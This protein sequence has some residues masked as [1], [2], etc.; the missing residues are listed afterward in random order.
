MAKTVGRGREEHDRGDREHGHEERDERDDICERCGRCDDEER[1]ERHRHNEKIV[2]VEKESINWLRFSLKC[3]KSKKHR[4]FVLLREDKID[5]VEERKEGTIIVYSEGNRVRKFLV[6]GSF[7][8]VE[9][10]LTDRR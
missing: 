10:K 8:E 3:P 5:D 6:C 7:D 9:D 2:V 1:G 4:A